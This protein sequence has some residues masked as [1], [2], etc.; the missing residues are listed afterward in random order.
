MM[1]RL[2]TTAAAGLI[3]ALTACD[4]GAERTATAD[5]SAPTARAPAPAAPPNPT[6]PTAPAPAPAPAAR[7]TADTKVS[8]DDYDFTYTVPAD[9]VAIPALTGWFEADRD[10]VRAGVAKD[11]AEFRKDATANDFPFR[12]Y[13]STTV[14]KR[15]TS[16]PRFLSLSAETYAYTGGAHGSPGF[17]GLVWDRQAGQRLEP[18]EIFT[19]DRAIQQA[20]GAAFCDALDVQRGKRRGRPVVRSSGDS[21]DGCPKVS[22]T[23]LILG[24]TNGQ[25]IDRIGL[26]VGPY[27]AGPYAE[28]AYDL[29]LPVTPTL[30]RA[31]KPEYRAG[32]IARG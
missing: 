6:T 13:E 27:V 24:S 32:F 30:L 31:V 12:K 28:G 20:V 2:G 19:S 26:L 16:T 22:E 14:W 11:A 10:A 4:G 17:R 5:A 1:L 15:V 3:L 9:V 25:A 29:T 18:T 8:T 23:T 21:F 7:F